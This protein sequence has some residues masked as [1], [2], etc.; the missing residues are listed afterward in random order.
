VLWLYTWAEYLAAWEKQ[1]INQVRAKDAYAGM[2]PN[3]E[4]RRAEHEQQ[5]PQKHE[6]KNP[7]SYRRGPNEFN[8]P[9]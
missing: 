1:E 3:A 9:L 4:A 5:Q 7:D 2:M 8:L 6:R